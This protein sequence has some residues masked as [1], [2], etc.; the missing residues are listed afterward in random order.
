MMPSRAATI[1]KSLVP[2]SLVIRF[3]GPRWRIAC[4]CVI[5]F[6]LAS[7]GGENGAEADRSVRLVVAIDSDP[8]HLNPAVTTSGGTHTASELLYSGLVELDPESFE[9]IPELAERWEIEDGGRLYRFHLRHDVRWHDGVP[10]TAADVV[11][12]F[13]HVLL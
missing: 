9:P 5:A 3:T 13:E 4:C 2:E 6:L 11:Y 10:F 1:L 7:C 8:G 12:T